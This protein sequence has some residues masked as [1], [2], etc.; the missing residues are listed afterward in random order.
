MHPMSQSHRYRHVPVRIC[1]SRDIRSTAGSLHIRSFHFSHQG[2]Y[3][4]SGSAET[5]KAFLSSPNFA[6]VGASKDQS[7]FGTKVLQWYL[8]RDKPVTP[9]HPKENE[10][11]GVST[12]RSIADLPD[13]SHTSVSIITNPK[14]RWYIGIPA[15]MP[16]ALHCESLDLNFLCRSLWAYSNK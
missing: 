9:I 8:A 3:T 6:V 14:V 15:A 1:R 12:V 11:E 16:S 10:L 4:M 2:P 13:P 5:K 7:K